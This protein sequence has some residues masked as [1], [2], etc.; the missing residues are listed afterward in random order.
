MFFNHLFSENN[1]ILGIL[2]FSVQYLNTQQCL[3]NRNVKWCVY[4]V[5]LGRSWR[6]VLMGGLLR[7][8]DAST[9]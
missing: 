9:D 7:D 4:L 1:F 3:A 5:S 6:K 8:S 2:F